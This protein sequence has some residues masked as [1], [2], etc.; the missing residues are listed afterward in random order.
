MTDWVLFGIFPYVAILNAVVV[1]LY[2]YFS[3][4]FS[5]SSYSSQFFESRT[6]FFGSI[7]WHY[8][9][10]IILL[11]HLL[12]V[13]FRGFMAWLLGS[14]SR[15]YFFEISGMGLALYTL[16][17]L[18]LLT[19]RRFLNNRVLKVTSPMDFLILLLLLFQVTTGLLI[20]ITKRWG[21][22][23]YLDTAVPWLLSL[24]RFDPEISFIENLPHIVKLHIL[25]G[26]LIVF[27]YPFT[28]LVHIFTFPIRY[29][30]RSYQVVVWGKRR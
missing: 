1:T 29:L 13:L 25:N 14:P 7:P 16:L 8:G 28:R 27:F 26:F 24:L 10:L 20:A 11:F 17:A 18:L 21:G 12:G 9:I 22:L 2:R 5:F 19:L 23:W 4:R 3:N 30:A 6:L 15:L